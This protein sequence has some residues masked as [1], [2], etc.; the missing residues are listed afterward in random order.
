MLLQ[1]DSLSELY[2]ICTALEWGRG[3]KYVD[4]EKVTSLASL[5]FC[6]GLLRDYLTYHRFV[7]STLKHF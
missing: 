4:I 1:A 3:Q 6:S 2:E 7:C 5:F